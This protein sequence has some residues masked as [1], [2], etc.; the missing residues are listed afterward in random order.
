[1]GSLNIGFLVLQG[2]QP[3]QVEGGAFGSHEE[4]YVDSL[5]LAFGVC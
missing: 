2:V 1:M 3:G 5:L 4:G